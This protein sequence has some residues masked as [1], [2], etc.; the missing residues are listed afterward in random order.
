[1]S[2]EKDGGPFFP[3]TVQTT[4]GD[5]GASIRDWFAGQAMAALIGSPHYGLGQQNQE[6][7]A[8]LA[9][10]AYECADA[11]LEARKK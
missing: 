10:F 5:E 2:K 7:R 9:Y 3:N 11:L 4:V 1:M 6:G 8:G